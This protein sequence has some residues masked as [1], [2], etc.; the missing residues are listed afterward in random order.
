MRSHEDD[1]ELLLQIPF[2]GSVTLRAICVIGGV[3]GTQPSKMR[4]YINRDMDFDAVQ[5]IRPLQE[6][7]LQEDFRGVL[8]YPTSASKFKGVHTLILHFPDILGAAT[9]AANHSEIFFIGL[10]GEFSE[11][12]KEAV[13]AVYE[14]KPMPE[15]HQVPGNGHGNI[16]RMGM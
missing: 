1:P 6:W 7:D 4:A 15:D 2:T 8:E 11:R 10:K 9:T 12:R 14:A 3:D 16:W 13:E 5:D